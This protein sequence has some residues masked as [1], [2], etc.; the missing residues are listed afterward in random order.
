MNVSMSEDNDDEV[1]VVVD[2]VGE[3][4]A[5]TCVRG[6]RRRVRSIVVCDRDGND[7]IDE[8]EAMPKNTMERVSVV[9]GNRKREQKADGRT[10]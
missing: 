2:A 1:V 6:R 10:E 5:E 9:V 3:C 8:E 7:S 4:M